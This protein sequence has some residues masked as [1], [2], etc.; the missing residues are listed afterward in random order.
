[1]QFFF[2]T[3]SCLQKGQIFFEKS[4]IFLQKGWVFFHKAS[5]NAYFSFKMLDFYFKKAKFSSKGHYFLFNR[6]LETSRE[7]GG[8]GAR[9]PGKVSTFSG[10]AE[11]CGLLHNQVN[12]RMHL[13]CILNHI[14]WDLHCSHCS[15][16][17]EKPGLLYYKS[18]LFMQS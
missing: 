7:V 12:H 15:H 11:E 18:E 6:H 13:H 9:I 4:Y 10:P 1:M 8:W 5:Q 2:K 14:V 3:L 17:I 16:C